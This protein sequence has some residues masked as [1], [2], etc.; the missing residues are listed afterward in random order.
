ML[1]KYCIL[2]A[3]LVFTA[4][5]MASCEPINNGET[6]ELPKDTI[7][8]ELQP[9]TQSVA[10]TNNWIFDTKPAIT[11]HIENPNAV[12]VEAKVIAKITT[13][14]KKA[15]TS[16]E[17]VVEVPANGT[18]D[19][20][21]TTPE[22][23]A[24]G[25][26]RAH[27]IVNNKGARTF[28]FGISPEK[29]VSAPDKQPD[30][31]EYWAAAK[32]QLAAIDMD[33]QLTELPTKST[34]KRKV[35]LVELKSV[36]DSPDGEPVTVRGY[37]A[38]PQDGQKHPVILHFYGYDS[39]KATSWPPCPGGNESEYAEFFFSIRGQ[40]LNNRAAANRVPDGKG[41][42]VNIY[43]DWFA[44]NFGVKDGYY[45]RG[46]FMD[47][48]QAVRFMATRETSDMTQLFA[49]GSS[50]GGALSYAVAALSDYPFT[51][52]APCVAFLGDFPDYFNIVTWP[53]ETAK[54]N[55]GSM[56][57]E[58]MYA[59]LSYFD[60]KNLATRISASVIACS[61]LQDVTCPPHTN[62]AP[63][64][65]LP[66]EDKVFYYYPEMGHEIPADWNKKIMAFFKERMK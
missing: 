33:A 28:N 53:A 43:G 31:D 57:N 26:Y 7:P 62:I 37:Y 14:L 1:K 27:C 39:Q 64:N 2:F 24:P 20:P 40:M 65:N 5:M 45:Y 3:A 66:T 10:V 35:Y 56:T 16:I 42:F 18:L 8:A 30:F 21:V 13:D 58:E 63:F 11:I 54:A 52:I 46:A 25:F 36:P 9:L 55:K 49:E 4:T 61:G 19:V 47:C 17:K 6:P 34:A 12:A 50:Q 38:E 32:E 48:V 22:D 60:T 41:D 15:V 51:A 23:L 29:I 44:Y 59:F